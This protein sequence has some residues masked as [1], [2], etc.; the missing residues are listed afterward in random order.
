MKLFQD[1][2]ELWSELTIDVFALEVPRL[3]NAQLQR[4]FRRLKT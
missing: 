4:E 1:G 3:Q 2:S